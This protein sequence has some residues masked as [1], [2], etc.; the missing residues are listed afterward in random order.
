MLVRYNALTRRAKAQVKARYV[1]RHIAIGEGR[2][3]ASDVEWLQ[4]HAFYVRKDGELDNRYHHC[5]PACMA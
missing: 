5:E 1:Y 3:Y 2:A 4:D